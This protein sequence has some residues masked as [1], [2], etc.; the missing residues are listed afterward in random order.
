MQ[1]HPDEAPS[2]GRAWYFGRHAEPHWVQACAMARSA[3][4]PA[5]PQLV[6]SCLRR[7]VF[8]YLRWAV[9]GGR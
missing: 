6:D 9:G 5:R 8:A 3:P 1:L 7:T 4:H 2:C